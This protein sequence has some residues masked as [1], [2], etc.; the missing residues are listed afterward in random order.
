MRMFLPDGLTVL[1]RIEIVAILLYYQPSCNASQ[2]MKPSYSLLMADV[3]LC[4]GLY[5]S[6][7][8]DISRHLAITDS[9]RVTILSASLVRTLVHCVVKHSR[10][11]DLKL[12]SNVSLPFA[13]NRPQLIEFSILKMNIFHL[14][15]N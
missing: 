5:P 10:S 11:P 2:P 15:I 1:A 4:C 9:P 8:V 14:I 12:S 13:C 3:T 7:K 6:G